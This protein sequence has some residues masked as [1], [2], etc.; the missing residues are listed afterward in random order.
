MTGYAYALASGKGGVGKTTSAINLGAALRSM[1]HDTVVV[2][3]DLAMA[4]LGS[5]LG[6]DHRPTLHDVLAGDA[7]LRD[8]L[9]WLST[10][11]APPADSP[12]DDDAARLVVVP[13]SHSLDS[14]A[15]ADP[16]RLSRV[17]RSLTAAAD[18]VLCDTGAGLSHENAVPLGVADGVVLV[19]TP[20]PV[21]TTDTRKA[22]E[23]A[24]RAG[25]TP[26]GAV[27]TRAGEATDVSAVTRDLGVEM[28]AV[29]PETDAVGREPLVETAP[30]SYAAEAY[31]RLA[32]ALAE[33]DDPSR[34]GGGIEAEFGGPNEAGDSSVSR[35]VQRLTGLFEQGRSG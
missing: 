18:F 21:A 15:A 2:D 16:G 7:D 27:L 28:L 3:T 32:A 31:R 24:E 10:T 25:G 22:A 13:G 5:L 30:D 35:V 1:G 34:A 6:I 4:N 29:V 33:R 20:D 23:F 8:A 17:I 11:D 19:T 9:V 26:V 12:P 14:F